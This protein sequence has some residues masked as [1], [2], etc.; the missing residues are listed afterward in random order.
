LQS[1]TYQKG[2]SGES[3]VFVGH[4]APSWFD[5]WLADVL[6]DIWVRRSLTRHMTLEW[7]AARLNMGAAGYI[8]QCLRQ[9]Q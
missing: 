9:A 7:I 3:L 1:S 8:D 4:Q 2:V 6:K 5:F